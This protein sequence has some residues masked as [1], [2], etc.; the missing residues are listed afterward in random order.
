MSTFDTVEKI[1]AT[2]VA[3]SGTFTVPYPTNRDD[4]DYRGGFDHSIANSSLGVFKAELG[5]I[6]VSFDAS[7]I[8][9]TNSTGF[10]LPAGTHI[11]VTLD[12]F[13]ANSHI[14]MGLAMPSKMAG[15]KLVTINLGAPIAP[16][17]DSA[18]ASQ[19]ATAVGGLATGIN[20][21][22]A[23]GGV[24]TFDAPRN[25]VAAWTGTAVL[26]VTGT[27]AYGNVMR[28]SSASGTSLT[29][30]KA[31]K[32]VTGI[33]VSADVT[34]LTVGHADVLGLPV[35]LPMTGLVLRE[36]ADGVAPTAGTLVA[37]VSGAATATTGDVR[38]TYDPNSACNGA[39][40]FQL[41]VA[42][43]DAGYKGRPQFAG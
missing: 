9:I 32:T 8:T 38:G 33:S 7:E 41:V 22:L 25:V 11:Y 20:G 3:N 26:T 10:T 39:I 13:G 17:A 30:K 16:D 34:G 15:M 5:Q 4:G 19:A 14:D 42:L 6:S 40:D 36:L 37:G 29:G 35:F 43:P 31:F 27:D 12:R 18:V 1:L 23:S 28:E 24:A 21:V 2:A